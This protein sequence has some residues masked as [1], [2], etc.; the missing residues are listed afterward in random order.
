LLLFQFSFVLLLCLAA[1]AAF[2]T[3]P[4]SSFP[5]FI[6]LHFPALLRFSW[7]SA[8]F[9]VKSTPFRKLKVPSK[10][11]AASAAERRSY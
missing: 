7:A 2:P 6:S 11:F 9:A 3:F 1:D 5:A 8:A 4:F 10:A